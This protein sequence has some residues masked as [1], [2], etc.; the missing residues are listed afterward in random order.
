MDFVVQPKEEEI[1]AK[2]L[3][4]GSSK[5]SGT[6]AITSSLLFFPSQIFATLLCWN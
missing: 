4:I 2:L 3:N 1:P 5:T 6:Y